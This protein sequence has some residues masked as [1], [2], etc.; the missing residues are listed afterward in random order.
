M[1]RD[2]LFGNPE[3]CKRIAV[4]VRHSELE[5]ARAETH[6]SG[7]PFV[8]PVKQIEQRARSWRLE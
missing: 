8:H 6:G 2:V 3:T 5:I 7:S 1:K 4:R